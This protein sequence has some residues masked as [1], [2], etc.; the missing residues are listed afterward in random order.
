MASESFGGGGCACQ[1]SDPAPRS[2]HSEAPGGAGNLQLNKGT[3]D[4]GVTGV[5]PTL[6]GHCWPPGR[7]CPRGPSREASGELT[8]S[9]GE[10]ESALKHIQAQKAGR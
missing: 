1:S 8:E 6:G 3:G 5:R 10:N 2:P 4:L 7:R 9:H